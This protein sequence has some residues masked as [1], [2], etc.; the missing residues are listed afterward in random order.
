MSNSPASNSTDLRLRWAPFDRLRVTGSRFV[1]RH[2][3][4]YLGDGL[5]VYF[6]YPVAR[7]DDAARA[8]RAG[9]SI[10]AELQQTSVGAT[11]R[12]H[13]RASLSS[14]GIPATLHDALMAR[15]DRLNTAKEIAQVGATLGREKQNQRRGR[16]AHGARYPDSVPM[17]CGSI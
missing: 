7:E 1:D 8:V 13:G 17:S 14:L 16:R 4:Q 15:L 2:I 6:G 9:L 12:A 10:L 11:G 3:A 5:L